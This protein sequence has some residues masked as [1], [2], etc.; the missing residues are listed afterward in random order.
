MNMGLFVGLWPQGCLSTHLLYDISSF[1]GSPRCV[2]LSD[3]VQVACS[4]KE[5]RM[6]VC[7]L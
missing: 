2:L 1:A 7:K 4:G 5:L 6:K 3:Q